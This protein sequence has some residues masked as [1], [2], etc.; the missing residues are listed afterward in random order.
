MSYPSDLKYTETHEWI[1]AEGNTAKI[2]ITSFAI[3]ALTDLTYLQFDTE[4]GDNLSKGETFGDIESVKTTSELYMPLSGEIVSI[5]KELENTDNLE[6]LMKD[7]YEF[8]WMLEV[9]ISEPSEL[10][11]LL[12]ME[13][14]EKHTAKEAHH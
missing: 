8:G 7:P 1:K 9:K 4:V 12:P 13:T 11:T 5:N 2:G 3:T 10:E 6:K 14:Y